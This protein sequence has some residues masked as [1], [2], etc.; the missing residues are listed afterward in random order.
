MIE[1]TSSQVRRSAPKNKLAEAP[2]LQLYTYL[3]EKQKKKKKKLTELQSSTWLAAMLL[4]W[5]LLL[6]SHCQS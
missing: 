5:I 1:V 3:E 6:L 2:F 4:L